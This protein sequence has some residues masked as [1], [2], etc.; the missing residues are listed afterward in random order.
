MKIS[1]VVPF[2]DGLYIEEVKKDK[3]KVMYHGHNFTVSL[4]NSKLSFNTLRNIGMKRKCQRIATE[5]KKI[6][7]QALKKSHGVRDEKYLND[8]EKKQA[9]TVMILAMAIINKNCKSLA[10]TLVEEYF[11]DLKL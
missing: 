11:S 4:S 9:Q 10:K 2:S 7:A 8:K 5:Y 3:F 1:K 6:D